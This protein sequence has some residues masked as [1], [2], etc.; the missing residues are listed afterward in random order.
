MSKRPS[1]ADIV[2]VIA[3]EPPA[4]ASVPVAAPSPKGRAAS[5]RGKKMILTPLDPELHK[6]LRLHAFFKGVTIE[7]IVQ[8]AINFYIDENMTTEEYALARGMSE[9]YS[10]DRA[11]A[12][13]AERHK[14]ADAKKLAKG[15]KAHES[16]EPDEPDKLPNDASTHSATTMLE[17]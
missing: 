8:E 7:S 17:E 16:D 6:R 13:K 3:D 9:Q 14:A 1:P 11:D 2:R 15:G 12:K 10:W 5:R 4:L